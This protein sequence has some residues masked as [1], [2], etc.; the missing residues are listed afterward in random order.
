MTTTITI[1]KTFWDDHC[2]R[3]LLVQV[4]ADGTTEWHDPDEYEINRTMT[5]VTLSLPDYQLHE[6]LSDANHYATM[7]WDIDSGAQL[8]RLIR[9]AA[10]TTVA[11][12]VKQL[13]LA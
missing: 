3:E 6:L 13:N 9:S 5:T 7:T 2:E 11:S 4:S 1:G 8:P 12:I 10:K